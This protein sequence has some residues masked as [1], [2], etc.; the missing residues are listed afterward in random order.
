M[1]K[2]LVNILV[3]LATFAGVVGL[4]VQRQAWLTAQQQDNLPLWRQQEAITA[5]QLRLWRQMPSFGFDNL[6][7]DW[8]LIQFNI[9]FGDEAARAA[10]TYRLVPDFFDVILHH[11]PR[12]IRAYLFLSTSGSLYAGEPERSIQIASRAMQSLTPDVPDSYYP[13]MYRGI[14]EMLFLGDGRAAIRSF[15]TAAAWASRWRTPESEAVVQRAT[16]FA[17]FLREDKNSR[18][19]KVIGWMMILGYA[20]TKRA[21]AIAVRKIL[22]AGGRIEQLPNG[23]RVIILPRDVQERLRG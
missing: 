12:F 9:Y 8:W 21:Q 10:L 22:E 7:A 2:T 13:W 4:Q 15:Q 11:D 20:P 1:V 5:T 23:R 6:I 3:G 18:I 14:D 16:Q 17:Q 19:A